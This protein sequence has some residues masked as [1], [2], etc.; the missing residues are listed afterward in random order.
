MSAYKSL[1][2]F[3]PI[4]SW[5][6]TRLSQSANQ[7]RQCTC[8]AAPSKQPTTQLP[9]TSLTSQAADLPPYLLPSLPA[10]LP[11]FLPA[12]LLALLPECLLVSQFIYNDSQLVSQSTIQSAYRPTASPI[13]FIYT[14]RAS[15]QP[16]SQLTN[17]QEGRPATPSSPAADHLASEPPS[18]LQ[19]I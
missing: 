10:C 3:I 9:T 18:P 6:P 19:T 2:K 17:Q 16:A 5:S 13:F 7:P 8:S 11:A 12:C 4:T 14:N 15:S 1:N